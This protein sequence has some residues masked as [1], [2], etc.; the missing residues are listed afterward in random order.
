MKT[1]G[2]WTA[3]LSFQTNQST[4]KL[5]NLRKKVGLNSLVGIVFLSRPCSQQTKLYHFWHMPL[6]KYR[7][8]FDS[9][10]DGPTTAALARK[11]QQSKRGCI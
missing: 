1:P 10:F 3:A 8:L 9:W 4:F 11:T 2:K 6:D 5:I 7:S